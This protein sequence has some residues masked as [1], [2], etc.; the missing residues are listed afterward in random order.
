MEMKYGLLNLFIF[1]IGRQRASC[2]RGSACLHISTRSYLEGPAACAE[3]SDV[4]ASA[5]VAAGQ[6]A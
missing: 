4:T 5:A 3:A 6:V 2:T 1:V